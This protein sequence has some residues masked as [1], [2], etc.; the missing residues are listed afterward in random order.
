[1]SKQLKRVLVVE[2]EKP[3]ARALELKLNRSGF[4]AK[5]VFG[6]EDALKALKKEKFHLIVLDLIMPKIDGFAVLSKLKARKDKTPVIVI[7]NLGQEEDLRR[8]KKLG[9]LDYF[10]KSDTPIAD[11]VEH[12]KKL[13]T[14]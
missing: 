6:G 10:V 14:L 7:T 5:A 9:A 2:D 3:I 13:F 1:M 8:A 11:I 4:E 12:I